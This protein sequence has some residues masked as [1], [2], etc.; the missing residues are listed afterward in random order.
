MFFGRVDMENIQCP[1]K[2]GKPYLIKPSKDF[3]SS[4]PLSGFT[5]STSTTTTRDYLGT[6]YYGNLSIRIEPTYDYFTGKW[7]FIYNS[8]SDSG[9]IMTKEGTCK[10][11]S[12][13]V[14]VETEKSYGYYNNINIVHGITSGVDS[15]TETEAELEVVGIYDLSGRRLAAPQPGVNILLMSDGS[16]RKILRQ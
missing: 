14:N 6:S 12:F 4:Q 1:L 8:D 13:Y 9:D 11:L 7:N 3:D 16:A 2:A 10:G 15:P 5:L